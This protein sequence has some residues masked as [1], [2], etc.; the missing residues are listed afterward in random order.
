MTIILLHIDIPNLLIYDIMFKAPI[1]T[2][3][4]IQEQIY[5]AALIS[6]LSLDLP[7][8]DLDNA[9]ISL[10]HQKN[11]NLSVPICDT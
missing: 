1:T 7:F 11:P 10:D 6:H 4:F 9:L 8:N 3:N 2:Q 5:E